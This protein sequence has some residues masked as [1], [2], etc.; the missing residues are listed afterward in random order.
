MGICVPRLVAKSEVSELTL[1]VSVATAL[2]WL[3]GRREVELV[4][5]R[6]MPLES[7]V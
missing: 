4:S 5:L 1:D 2:V 6:V 7:V 3:A